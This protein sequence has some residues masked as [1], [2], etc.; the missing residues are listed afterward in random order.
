MTLRSDEPI[1]QA[2]HNNLHSL[3]GVGRQ[4]RARLTTTNA[5]SG[6]ESLVLWR[7]RTTGSVLMGTAEI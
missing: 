5:A 1:N 2:F 7:F 4:R 6:L 3:T